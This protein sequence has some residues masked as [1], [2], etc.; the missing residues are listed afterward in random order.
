MGSL[1][2]NFVLKK[3]DALSAMKKYLLPS[4]MLSLQLRT[5][6]SINILV[7]ILR[8]QCARLSKD[9]LKRIFKREA[10]RLPSNWHVVYF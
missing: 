1:L 5:I 10:V 6:I 7:S 8:G 4:L 9:C 2:D 3:I